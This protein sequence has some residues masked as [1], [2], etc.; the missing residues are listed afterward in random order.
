[1]GHVEVE[2]RT[3]RHIMRFT[4]LCLRHNSYI[5]RHTTTPLQSLDAILPLRQ[6]LLSSKNK[7]TN[8]VR[9]PRRTGVL[10]AQRAREGLCP[11]NIVPDRKQGQ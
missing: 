1:M 11:S 10:C 4:L 2:H 8:V 9:H 6:A 7:A 5:I 3:P